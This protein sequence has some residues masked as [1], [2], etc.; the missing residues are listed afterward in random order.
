M[1][2]ITNPNNRS[3]M[4]AKIDSIRFEQLANDYRHCFFEEKINK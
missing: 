2:I 4:K 1:A 3:D